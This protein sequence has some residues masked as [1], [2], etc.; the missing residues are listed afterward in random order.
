[1]IYYGDIC[2]LWFYLL[3]IV[4]FVVDDGCLL[5][6]CDVIFN[7]WVLLIMLICCS[8]CM[9]MLKVWKEYIGIFGKFIVWID[10]Y[11]FIWFGDFEL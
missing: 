3:F 1:M 8:L 7:V 2:F 6:G 11:G 4:G 9:W 10:C 5:F